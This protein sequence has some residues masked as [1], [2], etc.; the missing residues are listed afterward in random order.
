MGA[1]ADGGGIQDA[2][3]QGKKRNRAIDVALG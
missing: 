1:H 2:A 3:W